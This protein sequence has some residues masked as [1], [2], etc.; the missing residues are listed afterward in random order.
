MLG[1]NIDLNV[2]S[3]VYM[4]IRIYR[5]MQTCMLIDYR[6]ILLIVLHLFIYLYIHLYIHAF[7]VLFL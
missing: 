4:Y 2:H 6:C 7:C 1:Y 5:Y 3:F